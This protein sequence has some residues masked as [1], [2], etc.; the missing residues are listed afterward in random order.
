MLA[1]AAY[2]EYDDEPPPE[3]LQA[4]RVE[5]WGAAA[6]FSEPIPAGEAHRMSVC[7]NVYKAFM[8]YRANAK[9]AAQWAQNYPAAVDIVSNVRKLRMELEL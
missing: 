3:L 2:A 9:N 6:L 4:F 5:Q 8:S 7:L 1:V